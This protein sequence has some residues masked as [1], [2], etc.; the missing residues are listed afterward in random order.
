MKLSRILFSS[1]LLASTPVLAQEDPFAASISLGYVGTTGNTD[2]TTLNT[3]VLLTLRTENWVHNAKFQGLGAQEND[4]T[5]AERY[6]LED[7]SDYALDDDQ[8][9][10]GKGSYTDDRFSGFEYQATVAAGYGRYLVRR[11]GLNVQ[12]FGG[13]G[14]RENDIIGMGSQGEGIITLGENVAWTISENAALTHSFTSDIGE[15]LTVSRFEIGL[16]TNIVGSITTKIAFQA[17]NTSE[18]PAGNKKTD[19]MTSVSLVY[20]F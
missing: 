5:K 14:Y 1:A 16:E 6:Y 12:A 9:L 4:V 17:R 8:Y 10:F 11:E 19:T 15:E 3:E 7:K 2:T 18:V 13:L 20:N